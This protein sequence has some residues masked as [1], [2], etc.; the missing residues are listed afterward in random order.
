MGKQLNIRGV[1]EKTW[2]VWVE[3][4]GLSE[5]LGWLSPDWQNRLPKTQQTA[6]AL[7]QLQ[8]AQHQLMANWLKGLG[9][10]LKAEQLEKIA[11]ITTLNKPEQI[12][13]MAVSETRKQALQQWLA[14][15]EIKQALQTLQNL[16]ISH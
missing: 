4:Y 2:M 12:E 13:K 16:G 3:K 15:P 6:N 1:G 9:I 7:E 14:A 11:A 8:Q 10:P 5:L